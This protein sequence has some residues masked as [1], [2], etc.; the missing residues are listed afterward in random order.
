MSSIAE[1]T[2]GLISGYTAISRSLPSKISAV[3]NIL[4]DF[5]DLA[6]VIRS[7]LT[8]R[9]DDKPFPVTEYVILHRRVKSG[10]C[11]P[12]F[13]FVLAQ[14]HLRIV[15]VGSLGIV[16]VHFNQC[17]TAGRFYIGAK[18]LQIGLPVFNV[19][20]YIMKET[21]I[22]IS[23]REFGITEFSFDRLDILQVLFFCFLDDVIQKARID[24]NRINFAGRRNGLGEGQ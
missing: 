20:K 22:H 17:D 18:R 3:K 19:M 1:S 14:K 2:C 10:S 5:A 7:P 15:S 4:T 12:A 11:H 13:N 16:S 6:D 21:Q 23:S 8:T 24:I 9:I